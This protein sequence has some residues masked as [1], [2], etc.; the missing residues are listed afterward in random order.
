MEKIN[1]HDYARNFQGKEAEAFKY[2]LETRKFEIELYWKRATYFWTFIGAIFAGFFVAYASESS[3][4]QDLLVLLCC[5][6]TVFSAAWFFVNKGSKHWQENWENHVD[7]LED[8]SVGSLFKIVLS[9]SYERRRDK[10]IGAITGPGSYSVS[11]INQIISLFIFTLWVIL[12]CNVVPI[13]ASLK[14][15]WFYVSV[16]FASTA[17]CGLFLVLGRSH[18]KSHLHSANL[19]ESSIKDV[20]VFKE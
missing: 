11:K 4:R 7:L 9:R 3:H 18:V 17:C 1:A 10:V 2:A 14:F 8:K 16:I 20:G 5:L 15:N 12:L 19:R 6:G 13:D